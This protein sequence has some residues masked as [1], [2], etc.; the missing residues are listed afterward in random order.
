MKLY[1]FI[2]QHGAV[3]T[4]DCLKMQ[5]HHSR[6]CWCGETETLLCVE[7]LQIS[8]VFIQLMK[9]FFQCFSKCIMSLETETSIREAENICSSPGLQFYTSTEQQRC[10]SSDSVLIRN[11]PELFNQR[12]HLTH[13][14]IKLKCASSCGIFTWTPEIS[15]LCSSAVTSPCP[16]RCIIYNS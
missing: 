12:W 5:E 1:M 13:I 8:W 2:L 10:T 11:T 3:S 15:S 6:V 16:P 4:S 14:V 9:W 7:M